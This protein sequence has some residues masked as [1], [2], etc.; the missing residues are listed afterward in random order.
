M[1]ILLVGSGA[2]EH[3]LAW[4][5]ASSELVETLWT[6]PGNPGTATLGSNVDIKA[7]D[8]AALVDFAKRNKVD[9]V[10][11]GPEDPL[12]NGLVDTLAEEGIAAFGPRK[13][14]AELEGSK[15]W[16]KEVLIRHR[17]PTGSYRAF[18]SL[19]QAMSYLETGAR[20][21]LVVKASG[22]A[23]GKGVVIC[24]DFNMA[25]EAAR[26]M[27][28]GGRFGEAGTTIV[29]EEFLTGPE[30]SA[31]C[32]TDG[33]TFMP[34]ESC[35]DHKALLDGNRG[36]NTGGMGAV[37]P[38]PE[39]S[40]RTATLI[41]RQI[42]LPTLHGM[43]RE[44]H[45]FQGVMFAGL[46]L[47][48]GGPK[49]IEYNVRFGDP[50]CQILMMRFASDLVPYLK[51]CS[52]GTLDQLE[53]PS[54]EKRPACCLVLASEGYPES[55]RTG[56]PIQGLDKVETNNDLQI[57]HAG[58]A[59]VDGE[60][61]TAGGRVLSITALGDTMAEA[62]QRAYDAAELIEFEGKT[63]RSDIGLA[64]EQALEHMK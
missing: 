45:P 6:A 31:F 5:M 24:E 55:Y 7:N 64:A 22:L 40:E 42:L 46:M 54:W 4:K 30:A 61:V 26:D 38:N 58:T 33:R 59:E 19:N 25:A 48:S 51:A 50:E 62:R 21:P 35:Q 16:C 15:A 43:V 52:D 47:T 29:V 13:G 18:R 23:A 1:R 12:V 27:L 41:E 14:A 36:P 63:M 20:Y 37:S 34:L 44:G 32:L 17:I 9:L 28:E 11:V 3:S 39:I 53:A 56:V 49:V 60:I 2:R 8:V 10:V 57:F